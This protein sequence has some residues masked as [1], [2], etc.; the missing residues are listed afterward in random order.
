MNG[1]DLLRSPP[2]ASQIDAKSLR[3]LS[4]FSP[5]ASENEKMLM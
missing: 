5:A 1:L 2:S 4:R 3:N